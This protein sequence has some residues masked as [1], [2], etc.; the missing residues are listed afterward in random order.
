MTERYPFDYDTLEKGDI[1]STDSIEK[2]YGVTRFEK[3]FRFSLL[4]ARAAIE[5]HRN[6]LVVRESHD[7]IH[8]LTDRE[9]DA[10][11]AQ[12]TESWIRRLG[13]TAKRTGRIDR[14]DFSDGERKL[15]EARSRMSIMAAMMAE[16]GRR[17]SRQGLLEARHALEIEAGE[18]VNRTDPIS[19][20]V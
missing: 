9:A 18:S 8:I 5:M 13:T 20:A 17:D 1:I 12:Q 19:R 11:L 16:K 15:S 2:I 14:S 7:A 4:K 10:Y 3:G 6:D